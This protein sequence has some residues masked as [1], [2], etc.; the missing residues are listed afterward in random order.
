[1]NKQM[2]Q[3][4]IKDYSFAYAIE[5]ERPV[6][7]QIQLEIK[8]GSFNLFCGPSGSGKTTLLRQF[9]KE[10]KPKGVEEGSI[11]FAQED[12]TVAFVLQHPLTKLLWTECGAN[13]SSV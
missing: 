2:V 4:Q 11:V 5:P 3:I 13:W 12:L 7:N 1:M 6:L 10:L 8:P 9:K